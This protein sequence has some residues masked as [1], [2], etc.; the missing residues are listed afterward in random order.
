MKEETSW[1]RNRFQELEICYKGFVGNIRTN[2]EVDRWGN[3]PSQTYHRLTISNGDK[4]VFQET[5]GKNL[6]EVKKIFLQTIE[7]L[8]CSQKGRANQEILKLLQEFLSEHPE[9]RFWQVIDIISEKDKDL[10]YEESTETLQ[11]VKE[12]LLNIK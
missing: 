1:K 10:F 6:R 5:Y 7:H 11:K 8:L 9:L 4:M 3:N 12:K 2:K